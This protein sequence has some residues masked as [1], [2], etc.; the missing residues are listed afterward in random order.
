MGVIEPLLRVRDLRVVFPTAAGEVRA[1]DGV[2]FDLL[3]GRALGVVGESGCGKSTLACAIPACSAR[4]ERSPAAGIELGGEDVLAASPAAL[5]RLRGGRVGMVF[6]DAA[7][8]LDPAFHRGQSASG[9]AALYGF[10]RAQ[11]GRAPWNCSRW[12]VWTRPSA[13]SGRSPRALRRAKAAGD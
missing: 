2:S 1:L 5:R 11:A 7:A 13:G 8:A 9:N 12:R 4:R 10:S 3:R 6:Q